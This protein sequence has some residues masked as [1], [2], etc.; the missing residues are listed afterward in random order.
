M[1]DDL[2]WWSKPFDALTARELYAISV[3]RQ[4]VFVVEQTCVYLDADGLDLASRHVWAATPSGEVHGY[5]RI[6][7]AGVRFA[8]TSIGRVV[9][10]P[11][12]RGTGL[13]KKL[14]KRGLAEIGPEDVRISAQAHLVAFY[15]EL[16]FAS[17]SEPYD[18]DGISHV[19]MLRRA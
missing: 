6:V 1:T 17:A 5:L 13:G 3:L 4:R 16:G 2:L 19:E 12:V 7:P 10:A 9:T 18:E 15:G 11:E 8:E 14:M